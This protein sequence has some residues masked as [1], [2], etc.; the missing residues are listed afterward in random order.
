MEKKEIEI[1]ETDIYGFGGRNTKFYEIIGA[2]VEID[3]SKERVLLEKVEHTTEDIINNFSKISVPKQENDLFSNKIKILTILIIVMLFLFLLVYLF[4]GNI[5]KKDFFEDN[6]N[7][8]TLI[9]EKRSEE[10]LKMYYSDKSKCLEM[11][12]NDRE[13]LK[14]LDQILSDFSKDLSIE[15]KIKVE[16]KKELFKMKEY[17]NDFLD[18]LE[19]AIKE[20]NISKLQIAASYFKDRLKNE[21]LSVNMKKEEKVEEGKVEEEIYKGNSEQLLLENEKE[22]TKLTELQSEYQNKIENIKSSEKGKEV[23]EN[24]VVQ[25]GIEEENF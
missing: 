9:T 12:E 22:E 11:I 5:A 14:K 13:E 23:K 17:K 2:G 7:K 8:V 3:N 24:K 10:L 1:E 18:M 16:A 15:K 4:S 19:G 21:K 20:G 6:K 25:G